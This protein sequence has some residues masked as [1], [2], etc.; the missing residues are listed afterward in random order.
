MILEPSS[1]YTYEFFVL[2]N[3]G[4]AAASATF[5]HYP[6]GI[7]WLQPYLAQSY[8]WWSTKVHQTQKYIEWGGEFSVDESGQGHYTHGLPRRAP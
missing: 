7:A 2:I 5:E 6:D 4:Y 1:H 8:I 3:W